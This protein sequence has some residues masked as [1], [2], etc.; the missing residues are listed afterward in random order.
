MARII[1][2]HL[3]WKI[4]RPP[5]FLSE[6]DSRLAALSEY[7][8]SSGSMEVE[9]ERIISLTSNLFEVPIVLISLVEWERQIF[10][11][12]M[13]VDVCETDRSV[14]FCA[15]A[16][17]Q[18]DVF[19]VLDATLDPRFFDNPLVIDE[20]KIRFYAGAPLITP[21][22]F[23]L[24]TLCVIDT[25]P[26]NSFGE[27][28]QRNLR[29]LASLVLDKLELRRLDIA[30]RSSQI[31]FEQIAATSPDGIICTD[32][33]GMIPFWNHAATNIFGHTAEEMAGQSIEMVL[34]YHVRHRRAEDV[35]KEDV[36]DNPYQWIG[37]T[38][39]VK[40]RRKDGSEFLT[41][42]SLSTWDDGKLVNY[43]AIVRDIT[44][45]RSNE[46][47]LFRLAHLDSLTDLPNRMVLRNRI[48]QGETSAGPMSVIV[49]DLDGFKDVNDTLGHSAGDSLLK[50]VADRLLTCVRPTDTVAR[51][52]GDEFALLLAEVEGEACTVAD[53]AIKRLSEPF[54]LDGRA[55]NVAASAGVATW[56]SNSVS[57]N[58]LLSNADLALYQ[59]K[60]EGRHC[61]RIFTP[62]LRIAALHKRTYEKELR[63]AFDENE[64]EIFYQPQIRLADGAL[65]GAEALLR[66]NHPE[67]GLLLPAAFMPALETSLLAVQ[68]GDW[69]LEQACA[70]TSLWRTQTAPDF[71]IGVNL[72]GAQ[73]RAGDLAEKV[74]AVL[75]KEKL[76][77]SALE[78][79][80]TEN[81]ILRN[82]DTMLL[83][84]RE[85]RA[86]GVGITFDDYGIGYASLSLLKRYPLTRLKIDRSFIQGICTSPEDAAIVR[87]IL[88]LG[89]SFGLA[90]IAEGGETEEQCSRLRKKGCEEVQGFLFGKPMPAVEFEAHFMMNETILR[91]D[92]KDLVI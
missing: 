1:A 13:G 73:F 60:A 25:K 28:D 48:K 34:P 15:H 23:G 45:R 10:P 61:R 91:F 71:R 17:R 64:F 2:D 26:R 16:L 11:A 85:L 14:S 57:V 83:P 78:L 50:Q 35:I 74:R 32:A 19:V 89:R 75:A 8:V 24:G 52:G 55:V 67:Q 76:A 66:W 88:H 40:A 87:A 31:R 62:A 22:G 69:V 44:E 46:D 38:I 49:L 3:D 80:I 84:L 90:V 82:D 51:M 70:Q 79:E 4:M 77:P 58:E 29:D 9:L 92:G 20:P 21:S 63:R 53:A 68:I 39:E 43:A 33:K 86:D 41:E 72:F 81:I 30:R 7:G 59:A 5:P 36:E 37:K 42:L 56:P 65:V 12:K 18:S 54:Y 6:E 47:R 27:D